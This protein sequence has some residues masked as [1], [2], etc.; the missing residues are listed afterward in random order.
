MFDDQASQLTGGTP[1]NL[2][3][4]EPEDMFDAVDPI[5]IE[6]PDPLVP[7]A[8]EPIAP[9]SPVP[10]VA[11]IEPARTA[12]VAPEPL[13]SAMEAGK[14]APIVTAEAAAPMFDEPMATPVAPASDMSVM[15][16]ELQGSGDP[17][18]MD[19]SVKD[20]HIGRTLM[21]IGIIILFAVLV[22]GGVWALVTFF[23][24]TPAVSTPTPPAV[25]DIEVPLG[26]PPEAEVPVPAVVVTTTAASSSITQESVTEASSDIT[27]NQI[28]FG[29]ALDTDEDGLDD[30]RELEFGTDPR[31]WDTDGDE[32]A[33][34][35]EVLNWGTD[36]LNPDTDGDGYSD[37]AEVA[38]GYSPAAGGGA[39]LFET[40]I[41][42]STSSTL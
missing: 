39:R 41:T 29:D 25:V 23:F 27:D 7:I 13:P 22:G 21:V 5:A 6:Q 8:P 17:V 28:L 37:G 20:P 26:A 4:G 40:V 18:I 11:P 10:V 42:S 14:L 36:P 2:P 1:N 35:V 33:D 16:P 24:R 19:H 15:P 31:N 34:G 38:S 9:I 30:D 32:L 3:I 12:E